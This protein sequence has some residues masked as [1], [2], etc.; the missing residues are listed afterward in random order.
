MA[1][2]EAHSLVSN[3]TVQ[4][5]VVNYTL[6]VCEQFPSFTTACKVGSRGGGRGASDTSACKFGEVAVP[7]ARGWLVQSCG[8]MEARAF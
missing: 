7:N 3:P 2:I 1:V 4:A 6:A 8:A 5:E